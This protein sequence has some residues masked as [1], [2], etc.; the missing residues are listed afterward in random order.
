MILRTLSAAVVLAGFAPGPPRDSLDA[1]AQA[2]VDGGFPG[3][4]IAAITF[5]GVIFTGSA[6]LADRERGIAM[7]PDALVHAAST[8]KA[9]TAVAVLQL[10]DAERLALDQTLPELLPADLLEGIPNVERIRVRDLL[11]HTS[12]LYSPN[13]DPVYLARYIGPERENLPFWSAAEIVRFAAQPANEPAFEPGEDQEYGDINYVL[14]GLVVEAVTNKPLEEFVREQILEP[15][16]MKSTY[17]LSHGSQRTRARGYTLDSDVLRELGL[18]PAFEPDEDGFLDTTDAQEESDGAAGIV[19]T[20]PELVRF[21]RALTIGDLLEENSRALVL[22]VLDQAQADREALGI[23][24]A[25]QTPSGKIAYA[26]GDGPGTNVLWVY[27][28]SA[29]CCVAVAVNQFGRW[30]EQDVMLETI[31]PAVL[32][33]VLE[34][35]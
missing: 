32:R 11:L 12:G 27:H 26:S 28:A 5:E 17:Y 22:Q 1:I 30:D 6:G 13:N 9:V 21:A 3:V 4:A 19:T 15:L 25:T 31:V 16:E 34:E 10:V 18:D 7:T 14:L 23:L 35:H 24:R 33:V 8:T 2:A 29:R 20:M